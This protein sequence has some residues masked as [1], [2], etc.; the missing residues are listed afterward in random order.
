MAITIAR[1][2]KESE[3]VIVIE[4]KEIIAIHGPGQVTITGNPKV[5]IL[6]IKAADVTAKIATDKLRYRN[7]PTIQDT[8]R[9]SINGAAL[10]G[11]RFI[12]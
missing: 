2:E 12:R 6:T 4:G 5:T 7:D 11:A 8:P 1:V 10:R 3:R 9:Q